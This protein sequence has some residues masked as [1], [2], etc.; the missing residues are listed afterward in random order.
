MAADPGMNS[1]AA[2]SVCQGPRVPGGGR[3]WSRVPSDRRRSRCRR[4]GSGTR[5]HRLAVRPEPTCH[6]RVR[7]D[8]RTVSVAV[9]RP[10]HLPN[11]RD[12]SIVNLMQSILAGL[13]ASGAGGVHGHLVDL[14]PEEIADARHVVLL[15]IDGLGQAQLVSGPAPA[16]RGHRRGT[17]TSVFPSTTASAVTTF[18]T[19]LAPAEHA[20][21]RVVH[22]DSRD[23]LRHR[24]PPVH[25]PRR[26][27]RPRPARGRAGRRL[28]RPDRLRTG[29]RGLPCG[30]AGRFSSTPRTR[31]RTPR[32]S[33]PRGF[34]SLGGLVDA[35]VDVVGQARRRTYVTAYWPVLDTLSHKFGSSSSR[36]RRHLAKIDMHFDR[37]R[38]ALSGSGAL[39]VVTA[40]HGFID[41][42][43]PGAPGCGLDSRSRADPLATAVRRAAGRLLLRA[44]RSPRGLRRM[45]R[46]GARRS[47]PR[48]R[49]RV[50]DRE[51]LVRTRR[52]ASAPAR[53]GSGT[54]PS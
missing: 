42:R 14:G 36:A 53:A 3:R 4:A 7:Y 25:H 28:H 18:L 41:V 29:A 50:D 44:R 11:Y 26:A 9:G 43:P 47:R 8:F 12:G 20:G 2:G 40:D 23:R 19:G 45:R 39:L 38:A 54:M 16:L 5:R 51:R 21:H 33:V 1:I 32:G 31:R 6:G 35:V 13:G 10:M 48:R 22:E 52:A 46:R 15:V 37:L 17:M 24:P 49:E 34:K 30:P 27:H